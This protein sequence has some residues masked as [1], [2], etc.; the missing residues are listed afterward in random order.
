MD[1][2]LIKLGDVLVAIITSDEA[3]LYGLADGDAVTIDKHE[4]VQQASNERNY[5]RAA[6][7]D[8]LREAL[9]KMPITEPVVEW[10]R[11]TDRY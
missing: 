3:A 4:R 11:L 8:E 6:F 2:Q 7:A 1:S 5:S 10:M 9:R